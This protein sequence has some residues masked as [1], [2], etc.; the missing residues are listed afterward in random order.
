MSIG[1]SKGIRGLLLRHLVGTGKSTR[2]RSAGTLA[3]AAEGHWN[4][5]RRLDIRQSLRTVNDRRGVPC[6]SRQ[7]S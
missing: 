7:D 3:D 2:R 6:F 4:K 5:C 1:T